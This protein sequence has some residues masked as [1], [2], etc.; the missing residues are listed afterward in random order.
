MVK[1]CA[2]LTITD[3][4]NYGNRLQNF[5]L[6]EVIKS[7]GFKVETIKRKTSHDLPAKVQIISNIKYVI[8]KIIG[9]NIYD[10]GNRLRKKNFKRFNKNYINFS[11]FMLQNNTA[12]AR[13]NDK[14]DY[15]VCGSDQIWNSKF[16]IVQEDILNHLAFFAESEKKIAYAASFGTSD[17]PEEYQKY[18]VKLLP[19]F[20]AIGVREHTGID[21]VHQMC[22]R[23]D[24]E[25]VLDPTL[26]LGRND[27]NKIA[28]K[29]AF[30]KGKKYILTYF[31]G[32]RNS[33]VEKRISEFSTQYNSIAINL[34]KEGF[35]DNRI[36]NRDVYSVSPDEFVWLIQN[37]ELVLTDSFHA[38]V[39]SI[40]YHKKFV[41]F[42]R[43]AVEEN[44]NMSGR[45]DTLF[46][47]MGIQQEIDS[48]EEPHLLP[49]TYD[50]EMI[51][52]K[53]EQERN[54][55][56][57][58]LKKALGVMLDGKNREN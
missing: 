10:G 33:T 54:K 58:F 11:R 14:Y 44:N 41:P 28:K 20:K 17:I 1:K 56:I 2:I 23:N 19:T 52:M 6:Q 30:Y 8:K 32:G 3:G 45:L 35:P 34:D 13:L 27:W 43:K 57:E 40:I 4:T 38:C 5:A 25:V 46:K 42:Q 48:M 16:R 7:L 15:F 47:K 26:L 55:S 51:D 21:L 24:T 9:W 49:N 12:P 29:P 31:L 18:F 53:L 37:A 36:D 50:V 39:F 22:G